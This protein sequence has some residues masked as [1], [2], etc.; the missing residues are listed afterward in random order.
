MRSNQV[1]IYQL[2]LIYP[3]NSIL[4]LVI[5]K[6]AAQERNIFWFFICQTE[7][8]NFEPLLKVKEKIIDL[9]SVLL[10]QGL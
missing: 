2:A 4:R 6:L 5:G 3:N 7:R 8:K 10:H 1:G 9:F